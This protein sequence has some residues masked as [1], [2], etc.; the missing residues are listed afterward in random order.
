MAVLYPH[1]DVFHRP[2]PFVL[3]SQVNLQK[4]PAHA[5][6]LICHLN[7]SFYSLTIPTDL[8]ATGSPTQAFEDDEIMPLTYD[9]RLTTSSTLS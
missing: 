4:Y 7:I 1:P 9:L 3:L 6:G 5:P 8:S 2:W